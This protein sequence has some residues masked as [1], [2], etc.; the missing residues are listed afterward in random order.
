MFDRSGESIQQE[1]VPAGR[2]LKV[3]LYELHDHLITDLQGHKNSSIYQATIFWPQLTILILYIYFMS[4]QNLF[5]QQ[6]EMD[7]KVHK[8]EQTTPNSESQTQMAENH[9]R[10]LGYMLGDETETKSS[11]AAAQTCVQ[12][13]TQI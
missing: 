7:I 13:W 9:T 6:Q 2:R 1:S 11:A 8:Y 4:I 10:N 5:I 3:L 12:R